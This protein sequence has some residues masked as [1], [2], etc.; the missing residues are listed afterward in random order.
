M[1]MRLAMFLISI[2]GML[3]TVSLAAEPN[4]AKVPLGHY[5]GT[6]QEIAR[7][8][9]WITDGCVAGF[10]TYRTGNSPK[11]VE[12]LD[13][14]HEGTPSGRLKT[15]NGKGH[16][17]D[18]DTNRA[19]LRVRY[20]LFITYNYWVLYTCQTRAGSSAQIPGSKIFGFTRDALRLAIS[21]QSWF[22]RL[23]RLAMT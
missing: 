14:C 12:V 6:W 9:M 7:R 4:V 15:V 18:A 17:L 21:Y 16:L 5:S 23:G 13:G 20:P 2:F 1:K 19:K 3:V 22:A 11:E 8:P 10:T